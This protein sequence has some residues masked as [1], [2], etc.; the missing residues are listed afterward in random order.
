MV[1]AGRTSEQEYLNAS[2]RD[3]AV[4]MKQEDVRYFSE[5]EE[6]VVNRL[7]RVGTRRNGAKVLVFL[8]RKPDATSHDI[9]RGSNLRESSVS[10]TMR[11][12]HE[13]GWIHHSERKGQRGP[14]KIYRLAK[15]I[16]EII[17]AVRK[18]NTVKAAAR[19]S[20][21][22]WIPLQTAIIQSLIIL[23]NF[24]DIFSPDIIGIF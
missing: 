17:G 1:P 21:K 8:A 11:Y 5:K 23:M 6:A 2:R 12:L 20:R 9:E 15:P 16:R 19:H 4:V 10:I 18:G 14:I 22:A 24:M 13:Q 3:E 7:V